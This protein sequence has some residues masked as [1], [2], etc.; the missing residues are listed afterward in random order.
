MKDEAKANKIYPQSMGIIWHVMHVYY[1]LGLKYHSY[2]DCGKSLKPPVGGSCQDED[3]A[4]SLISGL[5]L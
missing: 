2:F 1:C 5:Y 4:G 3:G